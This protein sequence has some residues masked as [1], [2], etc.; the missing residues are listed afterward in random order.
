MDRLDDGRLRDVEEIVVPLEILGPLLKS[1][2]AKGGFVQL[3]PLDHGAHGT[4]EDQDSLPEQGC[5][6][7]Y[8]HDYLCLSVSERL[9][10]AAGVRDSRWSG[11]HIGNRLFQQAMTV[12]AP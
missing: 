12:T 10:G 5:Y 4:V 2:P 11:H 1:C 7:M 6:F 9:A 3:V 8:R